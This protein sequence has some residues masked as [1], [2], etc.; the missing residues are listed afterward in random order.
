MATAAA[1]AQLEALDLD[2]LDAGLAHLGDGVGVALVGDDDARLEGD[3]VVAVVPLLALLLVL[4]AA[5]LDDV[6]LLDAEG[7]GD[8]AEE[9][10][11]DGDVEVAVASCRGAG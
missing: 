11:L 1:L 9:V 8:G 7:V 4:V 10:V 2:H 5:R 3:D 6:Q